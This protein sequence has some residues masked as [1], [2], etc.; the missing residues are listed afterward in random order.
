MWQK[1]YIWK[2]KEGG[3]AQ[4]YLMEQCTQH[5]R[6]TILISSEIQLCIGQWN[7]NW[8]REKNWFC[9]TAFSTVNQDH[10]RQY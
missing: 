8:N 5:F 4:V 6:W 7:E 2:A 9:K 10:S 3:K 1:V